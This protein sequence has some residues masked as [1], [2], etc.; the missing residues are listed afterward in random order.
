MIMVARKYGMLSILSVRLSFLAS[1]EAARQ[2][3]YSVIRG[4]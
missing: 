3:V 1:R 2:S 4:A